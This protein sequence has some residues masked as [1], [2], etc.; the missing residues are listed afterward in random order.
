MKFQIPSD[1]HELAWLTKISIS[2]HCS[3]S[4][5]GRFTEG[6]G[7]WYRSAVSHLLSEANHAKGYVYSGK[8]LPLL[9]GLSAL[10]QFGLC[11]EPKPSTFPKALASKSGIIKAAHNFL[12]IIVDTPDSNALYA[13]RNALMHQASLIS[14]GQQAKSKHYW[15]EIDNSITGLFT[16]ATTAWD[17]QFN[18]RNDSN[19]TI[20]NAST[21]L[22]LALSAPQKIKDLHEKGALSLKLTGGLEELLTNYVQLD[23]EK[24]FQ[25]SYIF[26]LMIQIDRSLG[27]PKEEINIAKQNLKGASGKSLKAAVK[28]LSQELKGARLESLI[29][30]FPIAV[31]D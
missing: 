30:A 16:H 27:L 18:N 14:V 15:F 3:I 31:T 11:Y 10:D 5:H 12:G 6:F 17:G 28:A 20:V 19:K 8:I 2:A 7:V 9:G 1:Q 4:S 22:K 26:Y 25:D 29:E 21:L 24:S 23:F 13:L